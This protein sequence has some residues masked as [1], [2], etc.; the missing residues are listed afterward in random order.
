MGAVLYRDKLKDEGA[1]VSTGGFTFVTNLGDPQFRHYFK[2]QELGMKDEQVKM[3]LIRDGYKGDEV[4]NPDAIS[5]AYGKDAQTRKQKAWA[6]SRAKMPRGSIADA[7]KAEAGKKKTFCERLQKQQI[8]IPQNPAVERE[9]QQKQR[10]LIAE[11][12]FEEKK[13]LELKDKLAEEERLR[14]LAAAEALKKAHKDVYLGAKHGRMRAVRTALKSG[15]DAKHYKDWFGYDSLGIAERKGFDRI[16]NIIRADSLRERKSVARQ[17]K[18]DRCLFSAAIEGNKEKVAAFLKAGADPDGYCNFW[19]ST[20]LHKSCRNGHLEI[21]KL[22]INA[23][24]NI[25]QIDRSNGFSTL[26]YAACKGN[27]RVIKY[28]CSLGAVVNALDHCGRS[29]LHYTAELG[30]MEC[31]NTFILNGCNVKQQDNC[32]RSPADCAYRRGHMEVAEFIRLGWNLKTDRGRTHLAMKSWNSVCKA[33][34]EGKSASE[35]L[36]IG[37]GETKQAAGHRGKLP[38]RLM[39]AY[40]LVIPEPTPPP[41]NAILPDEKRERENEARSAPSEGGKMKKAKKRVRRLPPIKR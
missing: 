23:G 24:A 41:P 36:A 4:E 39:Q 30:F 25:D 33:K 22:L 20:A 29:P 32:E 17:E 31:C 13:L 37:R 16:A 8:S 1:K 19:D 14:K 38:P 15:G 27:L 2:M 5:K 26:H 6:K 35:I 21:C 3:L 11:A 34:M 9:K 12:T 40:G 28:I 7:L 10:F 18:L